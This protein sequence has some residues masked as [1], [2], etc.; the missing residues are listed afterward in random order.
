MNFDKLSFSSA[1][2]R[3]V[4]TLFLKILKFSKKNHFFGQTICFWQ[5]FPG[6][7]K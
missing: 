2:S 6:A 5:V 1:G 4:Q 7:P 3:I